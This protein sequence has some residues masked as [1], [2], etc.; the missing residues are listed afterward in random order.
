MV[1]DGKEASMMRNVKSLARFVFA[2]AWRPSCG[3]ILAWGK[4][5]EGFPLAT[6]VFSPR[7]LLELIE[8]SIFAG[9]HA[10]PQASKHKNDLIPC[11]S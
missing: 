10:F 11:L 9:S 1:W 8:R 5:G 3:G 4:M 7:D 2:P 6:E